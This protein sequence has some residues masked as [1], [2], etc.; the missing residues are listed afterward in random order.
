MVRLPANLLED[1]TAATAIE[2]ALLAAL[3]AMAFLGGLTV[4]SSSTAAMWQNI[5]SAVENSN[6]SS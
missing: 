5:K 2:Y 4:L 6:S 3:I 1:Q